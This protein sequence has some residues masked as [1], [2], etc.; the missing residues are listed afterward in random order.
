MI[1][2]LSKF[3]RPLSDRFCSKEA[4][5]AFSPEQIEFFNANGYLS[6]VDVLTAE[7]IEALRCDLEEIVEG[8]YSGSPLFYEY[9]RNES[10]SPDRVLFH[11]LGAWRVSPAF[12]DLVFHPVL[13]ADFSQLLG[14][15]VRFWHD[16]VFVKPARDGG[17]VSWHQDYSYWT[18]TKP[19]AHATAWI[20]LDDSNE[21]NGCVHFVPGSHQWDPLPRKSLADDMEAVF[22][23]LT[24]DQKREFRPV[25]SVLKAGQAS[26]H[27]PLMLHGSFENRSERPRRAAVINVFRDGVVSASDEPLLAGVPVIPRG[28]KIEGR[29][30]PLLD[31]QKS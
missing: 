1:E 30:F 25:A 11:A 14:G 27:H 23:V 22:D 20:G 12:H 28:Q 5:P 9:N 17:V 10:G 3:R 2:D 4:A 7:E 24:E 21:D 19:M 29:F 8:K 15:P 16:Q 13:A 18:R 6:G 31:P 26:F